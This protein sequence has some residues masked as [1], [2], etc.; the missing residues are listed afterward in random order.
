MTS[1]DIIYHA[2]NTAT[3]NKNATTQ[4]SSTHTDL[5]N[6][7]TIKHPLSSCHWTHSCKCCPIRFQLLCQSNLVILCLMTIYV[8]SANA[9]AYL[10]HNSRSNVLYNL[11]RGWGTLREDGSGSSF[12]LQGCLWDLQ[13]MQ[14]VSLLLT[15]C[16]W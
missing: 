12:L 11:T 15:I 4:C 1:L 14:P 13:S 5:P 9:M 3:G 8:H 6:A 16:S 10:R 7:S 2:H